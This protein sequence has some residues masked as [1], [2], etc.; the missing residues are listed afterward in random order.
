MAGAI[1][2]A[3]TTDNASRRRTPSKDTEVCIS[4]I[5]SGGGSIGSFFRLLLIVRA[6][7]TDVFMD[8]EVLAVFDWLK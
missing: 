6:V 5:P 3:V 1:F 8:T 2:R 7:V 4:S